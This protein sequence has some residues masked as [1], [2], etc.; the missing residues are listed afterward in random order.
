MA[1]KNPFVF[2]IGFNKTNPSHIRVVEILN[3]T[4]NKARLIACAILQYFGEAEG[5]PKTEFS[6]EAV[7][8]MVAALVK[9]EIQKAVKGLETSAVIS[10]KGI[11]GD[12]IA[13]LTN[14]SGPMPKN[15][16]LARAAIDAMSAFRKK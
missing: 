10:N 15:K 6:L 13:D 14:D 5:S 4:E 11:E 16:E 2:T 7:R 8:P 12:G 1:K 9:Q 3:E